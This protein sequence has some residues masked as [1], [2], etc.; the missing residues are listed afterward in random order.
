VG[1]PSEFM[2][3]LPIGTVTFLFTDIEGST[4]LVQE[5]GDR[6]RSILDAHHSMLRRAIVANGGVEVSTEGDAF[7]AVFPSAV[8]AVRA[9]VDAQRELAAAA[10]PD[11][12]EIHVRMG[13]HTGE[14][15]L[16]GD[17]YLGVDV[18]RAARIAAAGHGDQ[19]LLSGSTR[20]LVETALPD[21]VVLRDLGQH[22]L[23]DLRLPE[24]LSQLVIPGLRDEFPALRTLNALP[25]NL[26]AP[27]TVLIGRDR[28]IAELTGLLAGP[29]LLTLTGPGGIGKTRLA[30]ELGGQAV[31]R[32]ADG[33]FFVPLE[34]FS[35]S[36]NVAVAV[37]QA[38][39]ARPAGRREPEEALVDHLTERELLL[40]LDNLEQL[41]GAGPFVARL[42]AG[43]PQLRVIAT[44]R[45]P[46]HLS[47]EQEYPVS[48][49]A[50]PDAQGALAVEVIGRVP[51]VALFVERARRVRPDFQLTDEN[52]AAVTAICRRLDGLALA[53]ELAA[54]RVKLLSPASMLARLDQALPM[55]GGGSLD[56][57]VRQR[58]LRGAID[59]SCRLLA[60][61]ERTFFRRLT[62]FSGGWT[63]EATEQVA[64]PAGELALDALDGLGILI[65]QS[66]VRQAVD[67]PSGES[68]FEMLQLI[69]EYGAELL[70]ASDDAAIVGRR[71]ADWVLGLFEAA[72]PV[73]ESGADMGWLDRLS[74]EHDN[75]RVASRWCGEHDEVE[76]GLRLA[77]AAWRFWQQRGHIREGRGWS[78]RFLT[79]ADGVTGLDTGVLAAAR[80][81]AG[82][83]AYW[84]NDLGEAE[85]QYAAALALD[86][87]SERADRLGDDLYNLGFVS[88]AIGD[89]NTARERFAESADLFASA[90]NKERQLADTTQV[91]GALEMRAGNFE[92]ARDWIL[93]ARRLQLEFGNQRRATD[94]AIVLTYDSF[95]LGDASGASESLLIAAGEIRAMDDTGRWSL[96]LEVG[97]VIAAGGS[98]PRD[99]VLLAGAA[100]NRR[101]KVGGGP[102][103][104][105]ANIDQIIAEAK[106]AVAEQDGAAAVEE[107]WAEGD[108]LDDDALSE[109]LARSAS[110]A[111]NV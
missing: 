43:A 96:L 92:L 59:W 34:T 61:D 67:G 30:L 66:L 56:L 41:V 111:A 64:A 10:W 70:A 22:R 44:S 87:E 109:I 35:E 19:V 38:I 8:H 50:L 79:A 106:A 12:V 14:A 81:A 100:A 45:I 60:E 97:A 75:L 2:A 89:L 105:L 58:T 40:I 65:D 85:R 107:A 13:L 57:P 39:G 29:R 33:V 71:H 93:Q 91:Q 49:L 24:Q 9:T 101:A 104:F 16:G 55:L 15:E 51:A 3:Q 6:Y 46:L 78:D 94:A 1:L 48:P 27:E 82:G 28:E 18:N 53:I 80:T 110:G 31:G 21:D 83:I 84:Q 86:R 88:M 25:T 52:V 42:L 20:A 23:K 69:R 5:L 99:A 72:A 98:Q 26:V 68:R 103:N 11:G 102:P 95:R 54:A 62:V 77:A 90:G 74:A 73:L 108:G 47:G 63:L 17:N 4:R 76:I 37:A 7:F 32:F 36:S